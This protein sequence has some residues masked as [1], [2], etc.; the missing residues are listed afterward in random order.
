MK[1][2]LQ[3]RIR[4]RH[5]LHLWRYIFVTLILIAFCFIGREYYLWHSSVKH[6]SSSTNPT[7]A[8]II[9]HRKPFSILVMGTDV[10][11]LGR[12][13]SYAGNTDTMEVITVNPQKEKITM[14]AIPRD[15]LVKVTTKDGSK[16]VK[17]NA[18]YAI[19]GPNQAK[20]QVSELLGMPINFYALTNMGT[21]RKVVDAVG[22]VNVNNPFAFS[23]EG[24][25]FK[26]GWQHLNGNEALKYSRMR[27][28]DSNNDYGR[29]KRGQQVIQSVISSFKQRGSVHAA[30]EIIAAAKDGVRTDLPL[31][32]VTTLYLNYHPAM[33]KTVKDHL[34]GKDA[35]IDGTDFQIATA[36]EIN[37]VSR[38]LRQSLGL[39]P[40]KVV[41]NETKM[42]RQ[43]TS[44]NG[45]NQVDYQ[46]PA[47]AQYNVLVK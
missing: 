25:H 29:Q 30:N 11:A 17:I 1:K 42:N 3:T 37:R 6:I 9:N 32:S 47:G 28:D 45:Y 15:T 7:A 27:Y 2:E 36:P 35:K 33:N 31:N 43:Q 16:Y 34:Q 46:L 14:V 21:L 8:K 22:G 41:N 38:E 13:T 23:Y 10:G 24:H 19:G 39:A 44:W 18:A 5:Q 26:K 12:G 20:K 4:Q 40:I